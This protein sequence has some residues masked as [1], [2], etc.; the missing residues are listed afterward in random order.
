VSRRLTSKRPHLRLPKP[1]LA[2]PKRKPRA[3]PAAAPAHTC[4][5]CGKAS[6]ADASFCQYCGHPFD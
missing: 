6:A 4:P 5:S 1:P 2:L 3:L